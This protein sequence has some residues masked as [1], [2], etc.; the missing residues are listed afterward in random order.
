MNYKNR[1]VEAFSRWLTFRGDVPTKI[2]V[3]EE[4]MAESNPNRI[5]DSITIGS[6]T[7]PVRAGRVPDVTLLFI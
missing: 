4:W 2:I 5:A 1:I 7:I 3:P 6:Y